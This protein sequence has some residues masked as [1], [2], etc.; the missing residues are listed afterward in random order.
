MV[1]GFVVAMGFLA[2]GLLQRQPFDFL[3]LSKR[4]YR[5][6]QYQG[7]V[8]QGFNPLRTVRGRRLW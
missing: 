8:A 4:W 1:F 7:L 3:G 6:R 2:G 5:R